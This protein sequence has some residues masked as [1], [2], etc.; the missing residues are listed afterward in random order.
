MVA[1]KNLTLALSVDGKEN[2]VMLS[3][4]TPREAGRYAVEAPLDLQLR[5]EL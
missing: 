5:F 4:V 1:S 3:E 2:H